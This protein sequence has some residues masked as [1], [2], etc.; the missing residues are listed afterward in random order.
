MTREFK[1]FY[2]QD[3]WKILRYYLLTALLSPPE[4]SVDIGWAFLVYLS[5]ILIFL[6]GINNMM[7][8]T[9][10]QLKILF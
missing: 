1:D 3:S 7:T 8:N 5:R 9:L 10:K 6:D 2:F 4:L